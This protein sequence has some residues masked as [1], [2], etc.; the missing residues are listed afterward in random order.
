MGRYSVA[1][2]K[3]VLDNLTLY[4]DL[5]ERWNPRLHLV[6]FQSPG[7]FATRHVLESL[8]L[9]HY[10]PPNARVADVGSGGGLPILPCLL[11]RPDLRAS[12]IEA[13]PRKAVFLRT[14]LRETA[15]QPQGTVVAA[16]F[17]A[18]PTPPADFITCRALER[19]QEMLPRLI[20]WSPRPSTLL[21]FGGPTL[22]N[23]MRDLGL[24]FEN[25]LL[26]QS[27]RRFLYVVTKLNEWNGQTPGLT[28]P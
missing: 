3:S 10:L 6:A 22:G 27:E 7:E 4:Y 26:P 11:A 21:L 14:A 8:M 19:F 24:R 18:I 20:G 9:L 2:P 1:L 16:R 28:P 13:S 25:V 23:A 15:S 5:L 17:E 12:L